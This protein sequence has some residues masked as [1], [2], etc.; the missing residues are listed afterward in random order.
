MRG[1]WK[2][3]APED[4]ARGQTNWRTQEEARSHETKSRERDLGTPEQGKDDLINTP[5]TAGEQDSGQ[6]RM[7]VHPEGSTTCPQYINP[8]DRRKGVS[9]SLTTAGARPP[10][11]LSTKQLEPSEASYCLKEDTAC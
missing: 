4:G 1:W 2:T 5:T 11:K 9:V 3:T 8:L 10:S 6:G 7:G